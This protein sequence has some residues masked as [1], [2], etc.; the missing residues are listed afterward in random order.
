MLIRSNQLYRAGRNITQVRLSV[1][2]WAEKGKRPVWPV[3]QRRKTWSVRGPLLF[4][5]AAATHRGRPARLDDIRSE[6]GRTGRSRRCW[7][8]RVRY[9]VPIVRD[10]RSGGR[11]ARTGTDWRDVHAA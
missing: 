7:I 8:G 6:L 5:A 1:T 3:V 9:L 11:S 2:L 10:V 4:L